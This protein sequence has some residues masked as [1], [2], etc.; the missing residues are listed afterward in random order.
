M[1][2]I[3][4]VCLVIGREPKE[5]RAFVCIITAI[6]DTCSRHLT[7][8]NVVFIIHADEGPIAQSVLKVLVK[9][10]SWFRCVL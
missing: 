5:M 3:A 6:D 1:V 7:I 9:D 2:V 10:D 4:I 8:S